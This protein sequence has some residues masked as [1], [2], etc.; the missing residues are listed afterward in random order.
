VYGNGSIERVSLGYYRIEEISQD[1]APNGTIRITGRDRM[2]GIIDA[3]F[4][5]PRSYAPHHQFGYVLEELVREVYPNATI[6]WD[7]PNARDRQLG[8]A[9]VAEE[10]RYAVIDDLV[11]SLGKI[12]YWDHRGFLVIKSP[13]SST[14]PVWEVNSGA[15][16]VLVSLARRM[17]REGVYNAVVAIGEGAD[18]TTPVRAVAID[19]DPKSP[20]YWYGRFGKVPRR[21]YSPLLTTQLQA[22]TAAASL[23]RRSLGVPYVVDFAAIPNPALE[24]Y[25]PILITY[26]SA[27]SARSELHIIDRIRIPLTADEAMPG[28]TRA[29]I[30][31]DVAFL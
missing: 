16:G 7:D 20:T 30:A 28:T 18:T 22:Q 1:N 24:P 29:Q 17:S 26:G 6:V 8:R 25:D 14:E 2:Q 19:N 9:I 5:A 21:Y 11:T 10:D 13:P 27:R 15:N 12:W 31:E 3:R 23:L 4:L